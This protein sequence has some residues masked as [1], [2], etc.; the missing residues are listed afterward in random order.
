MKKTSELAQNHCEDGTRTVSGVTA[1]P[2][3]ENLTEDTT[4]SG[5]MDFAPSAPQPPK[6]FPRTKSQTELTP[7]GGQGYREVRG[8]ESR[9]VGGQGRD[10][11]GGDSAVPSGPVR[12]RDK[13]FEEL[14]KNYT[15]LCLEVQELKKEFHNTKEIE[16]RAIIC[17]CCCCK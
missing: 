14:S 10:S 2:T 16:G 6:P 4:R 9:E 1:K 3:A 8:Q 13:A 7:T 11:G 5:R 15:K 12:E 17:C